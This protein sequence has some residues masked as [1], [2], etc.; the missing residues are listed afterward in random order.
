MQM[1]SNFAFLLQNSGSCYLFECGPPEDFKCKFTHHANYSS[2]ILAVNR[3]LPDLESQIKLTKHEQELA[4]LRKSEVG[5]AEEE[6]VRTPEIRTT[7]A[8]TTV[9][10]AKVITASPTKAKTE[11]IKNVVKCSRYQFEC[12][13]TKECIGIYNA[14]DGIPQCA[15][16]SDEGPE[17][18]CPDTLTTPQT[19]RIHQNPP[20]T[21]QQLPPHKL[22]Q[23]PPQQEHAIVQLSN[24]PRVQNTDFLR[25]DLRNGF[26]PRPPPMTFDTPNLPQYQ[27]IPPQIQNNWL[28]RQSNQIPQPYQQYEDRNSHIFNHKEN[29]LQVSE[30]Q[31][32]RYNKHKGALQV[33]HRALG[34]S[35]AGQVQ[36]PDISGKENTKISNNQD[37]T[38]RQNPQY[39]EKWM[40]PSLREALPNRVDNWQQPNPLPPGNE[41]H[42]KNYYQTSVEQPLIPWKSEKP[43]EH[44]DHEHE[45]MAHDLKQSK[46][47]ME[48][49]LE[50]KQIK[51]EKIKTHHHDDAQ[52]PKADAYKVA[53]V[54]DLQDGI[55]DTPSGAVLS[56]TLGLII[57]MVMALLIGCRLRVVRRKIRRGGKSYAHDADYLVNGMY[58]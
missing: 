47:L 50:K 42:N 4:K 38:Y 18:E 14:C 32:I 52:Y 23:Q 57:T 24:G 17:L 25:P 5:N 51:I 43:L 49:A 1:P 56:L 21:P 26:V 53:E 44:E 58:L 9:A 46:N 13:S 40:K 34:Y 48:K 39:Q 33:L 29:G 8:T 20:I 2:A 6:K 37:D 22:Y 55:T 19:L 7:P 3:H 31:D 12:R 11:E 28:Q 10:E 35:S 27:Q 45:K 16:G 41:E 15:D 30:G 36:Y 54:L